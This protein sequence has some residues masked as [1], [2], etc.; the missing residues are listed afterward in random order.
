MAEPINFTVDAIEAIP[1]PTT[2]TKYRD[3]GGPQSRKDLYLH[4]GK[5][6]KVFYWYS[7]RNN[8]QYQYKIG[9]FPSTTI[10]QARDRCQSLASNANNGID[11]MDEKRKKRQRGITLARA[12]EQ[13]IEHARCR[14]DK[15][16]I[17]SS[18]EKNYRRSMSL[19]F[20]H[21]LKQ[22]A[23]SIT[24]EMV[25]DWFRQAAADSPT[26]ANS[27]MRVARAVYNR[28]QELCRQIDADL[29]RLNPFTGHKLADEQPREACIETEELPAWFE[30]VS[31]LRSETTRDYLLVLL[32]TGLR[33]REAASLQWSDVNLT[34][35]TLTA[36]GTKNHKDHTI[37]LSAYLVEI[38]ARR[39]TS[40]V[41][42]Y[43]FASTGKAGYLAEPKK[44]VISIAEQSGVHCSP[45][46]LRRT[47]SN[48]AAFEA[49][50]PEL[51]RKRLMNHT[52]SKNDVTG[53]H[54]SVL[55]MERLRRYQQAVCDSIL[56]AAKQD[57]PVADVVKLEVVG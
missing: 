57:K 13:Y 3:A 36:R 37:P 34:K 9:D 30:A 5:T 40:K 46:G 6:G 52:V 7:K 26:S 28:Q 48:F 11:P 31:K 25:S 43:V 16:P 21:W 41:T 27:A 42:D 15:R 33:R 29:F 19:H 38:F 8:R 22:P 2:R 39:K 35:K 12:F 10:K 32:F 44:A 24:Y 14:T 56:E 54:Y 4:V 55:P 47:Y 17:G 23:E 50:I 1:T 53:R 49:E 45:H 51:A 20:S 18:T